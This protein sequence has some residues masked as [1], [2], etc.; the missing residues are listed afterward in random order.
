MII[1][2]SLLKELITIRL[3]KTL[4]NLGLPLYSARVYWY[5]N[6]CQSSARMLNTAMTVPI[7]LLVLLPSAANRSLIL[8]PSLLMASLTSLIVSRYSST[9][10]TLHR[11]PS[12]FF[13]CKLNK[14]RNTI[15][16]LRIF[17]AELLSSYGI[18]N[19]LVLTDKK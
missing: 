11:A 12:P 10:L 18:C 19:W 15:S 4:I 14:D 16:V 7:L 5:S 13:A 6:V 17:Q 8:F 9:S 3:E 2:R 1:I